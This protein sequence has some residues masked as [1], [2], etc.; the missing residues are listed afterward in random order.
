[1]ENRTKPDDHLVWAILCTV[2]C[3]LPLGVASILQSTKVD[4]L[5]LAG[6]YH[7]AQE[8][9]DKAKK[10]AVIGAICTAV[11]WVLYLILFIGLGVA[12]YLF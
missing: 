2:C 3:C 4:K 12:G 9:A 7:G 5:Y 10:Y 1:M 6:D 11:L 8:A